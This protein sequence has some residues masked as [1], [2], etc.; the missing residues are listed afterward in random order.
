MLKK[1]SSAFS[2]FKQKNKSIPMVDIREKGFLLR[3]PKK[4]DGILLYFLPPFSHHSPPILLP[5]CTIEMG[6]EWQES[7]S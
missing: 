7:G 6:E 5:F 4:P 1:F 2:C 3:H